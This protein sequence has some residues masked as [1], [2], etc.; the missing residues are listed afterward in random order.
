[1]VAADGAPAPQTRCTV[2]DRR[3]AELS[4]LV[5][6]RGGLWAMGDGG[7]RVEV[8]RLDT[9]GPVCRVVESR[10]A[11][12]DPFDAEDLARGPDG[13]LWVADTGDNRRRRETVALVAL[14]PRGEARLH[15]LTYPDGPHDGEALLI[16]AD[17]VPLVITKETGIAAGIYRPAGPLAEPGPTP[18]VRVGEVMLPAS[19]SE[20]GPVGGLGSRLVTGAALSADGRVAA[21]R[22]YTDAWLYPV[23]DDDVVA[24]LAGTPVRVPLPDEPQGEAIAFDTDGTLL[25]GSE[26][27]GGVRGE[28]RA[29]PAA[30]ALA[31]T[32]GTGERTEPSLP[33]SATDESPDW[34]P[35]AVGGTAAVGLLAVAGAAMAVHGARRRQR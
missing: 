27:R 29:V 6:D 17:G 26:T 19:D 20:G 34:W 30:A 25:S 11:R 1:M 18:L 2:E 31:A 4:G 15:R 35:A 5:V 3:L 13:T 28:I 22:S 12:I 24:A 16:G 8:H 23:S 21:L 33:S 9:A 32:A 7:R 10:T 14:P